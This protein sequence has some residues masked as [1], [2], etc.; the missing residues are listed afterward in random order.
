M[1]EN[2]NS[3]TRTNRIASELCGPSDQLALGLE[4]LESPRDSSLSWSM[5]RWQS[6]LSPRDV[7]AG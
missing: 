5:A 1:R 2:A 4:V 7:G 6:P 3:G